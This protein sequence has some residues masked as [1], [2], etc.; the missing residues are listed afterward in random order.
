MQTRWDFL[1]CSCAIFVVSGEKNVYRILFCVQRQLPFLS[2]AFVLE[3]VGGIRDSALCALLVL[4]HQLCCVTIL[5]PAMVS[6]DFGAP[7][8]Y[9][10]KT[11]WQWH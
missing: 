10:P 11:E 8:R 2:G 5:P 1:V 9:P 6:A 7:Q 3:D 4:I